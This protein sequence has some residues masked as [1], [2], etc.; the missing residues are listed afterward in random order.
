MNTFWRGMAWE[1]KGRWLQDHHRDALPAF[2]EAEL[3]N[4]RGQV[5]LRKGDYPAAVADFEKAIQLSP[6]YAQ[7]IRDSLNE[8]K[9]KS[10]N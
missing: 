7:L 6:N 10:G 8:A 1:G 5:R 9:R 3:Y 2:S 4:H